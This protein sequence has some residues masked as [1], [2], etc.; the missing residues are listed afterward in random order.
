M[1]RHRHHEFIK[2]LNAIERAVPAGKVIHAI[3]DN[4]R[5]HKHPKVQAW[6]ARSSATGHPG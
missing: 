6:L 5:T 1:P 2:F 4:Y 3:L